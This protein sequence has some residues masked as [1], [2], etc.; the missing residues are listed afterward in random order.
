MTKTNDKTVVKIIVASL[1]V[2]LVL[3][4]IA[5]IVNLVRLS[6]VNKRKDELAAQSAQLDALIEEN[7]ELIA[8]CNSSEFV[9][10][11]ARKYLDM[12]YRGEIIVDVE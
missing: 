2:L 1:A 5:L 4:I 10:D 3:F 11:Y 8:Y 7:N 6:A 9:E 12:V